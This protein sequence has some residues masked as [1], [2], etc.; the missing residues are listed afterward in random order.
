MKAIRA[1][2]AV[3]VV[4]LVA[5]A[6]ATPMA[7]PKLIGTVGP[8]F[9][10]SL[11]KSGRLVKTLPAGKYTIVVTDK[12]SIHSFHL[13]GPG[14]TKVITGVGFTGTK[15]VTVLLKKGTYTYLCDVHPTTMIGHVKVV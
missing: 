14:L 1:L 15:T 2:F 5:A 10:I 8:G 3:G 11:K 13:K 9:T 12:A 4:A 6:A 7:T